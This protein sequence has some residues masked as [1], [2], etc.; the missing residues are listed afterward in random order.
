MAEQILDGNGTGYKA[1]VGNDN[2]LQVRALSET[3]VIHNAEL[4]T[5]YNINTGLISVSGDATL[6]YL[7]NNSDNSF[8]VTA[9]ATGAFDGITHS[10]SP[11]FTLVRNPTGGDIISDASAVAMNA[12]RNFGSS[13][14]AS[15]DVY[16]G[17][18]GGTMTGGSDI[19]ILQAP[20]TGRGF[21][22]IDFLLP[23]GAS[24][25][26][27][28][29]ANLTSGSANYYAAVIGYFKDDVDAQ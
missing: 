21:Y 27:K 15:I 10:D 8:I 2:R 3:E 26:L 6:V 17:K 20:K 22:T 23:K 1:K 18:T 19:A 5:A 13:R 24:L 11:Y 9:I 25:G 4:G 28:V 16:K 14:T 12:N 29:T 7:K